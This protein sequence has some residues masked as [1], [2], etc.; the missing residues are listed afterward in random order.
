MGLIR[1][2]Q[3]GI[4]SA[5]VILLLLLNSGCAPPRKIYAKYTLP[6]S[7]VADFLPLKNAQI[8]K[9]SVEIRGNFNTQAQKAA[10]Q[11]YSMFRIS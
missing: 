5:A 8:E 6:P 4:V 3:F 10:M 7:G 2:Q 11:N 1:P 9:P